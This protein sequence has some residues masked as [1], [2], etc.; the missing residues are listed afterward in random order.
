MA[1]K[2]KVAVTVPLDAAD[3][4]RQAIGQAGGGTMGNYSHCSFSVRGVGRFRPE[5]GAHP[6]VGAIGKIE[7][8]EEERIEVLCLQETL[9]ATLKAIKDV[10]PYDEVALDVFPLEE[11]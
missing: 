10:H 7:E 9:A 5:K 1:K 6:H 8:V 2:Y 3:K 11:V 4:V